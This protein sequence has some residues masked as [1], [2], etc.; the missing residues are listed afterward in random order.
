MELGSVYASAPFEQNSATT[1]MTLALAMRVH[2]LKWH[3]AGP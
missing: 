2:A 1:A 3:A